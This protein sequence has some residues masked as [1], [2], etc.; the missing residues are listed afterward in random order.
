GPGL[1]Y[2]FNQDNHLFLNLYFETDAENRA[3]GERLNIRYIR[4]F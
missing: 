1:L 4:H 3:E 2:S